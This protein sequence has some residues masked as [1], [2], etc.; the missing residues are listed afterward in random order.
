MSRDVKS[1]DVAALAAVPVKDRQAAVAEGLHIDFSTELPEYSRPELPAYPV[2]D[3]QAAVDE[4]Y[5]AL[6]A[7]PVLP[8]R[9]RQLNLLSKSK[10][11]FLIKPVAWRLVQFPGQ[12]PRL[13]VV[14]ERP[15]QPLPLVSQEKPVRY[16]EDF[17]LKV[18][19]PAVVK[20]LREL[21]NLGTTHGNIRPEN[22]FFR[23]QTNSALVL[24]ESFM[25]PAGA[26]QAPAFESLERALANPTARGDG[27]LSSDLFSLGMTVFMLMTGIDLQ[28]EAGQEALQAERLDQGTFM[29]LITSYRLPHRI[30]ELLRGLLTDTPEQRWTLDELE[31]WLAG[32]K[33]PHRHIPPQRRPSRGFPF[34]GMDCA[35]VLALGVA[36]GK[37][38][39]KAAEIFVSN[40][41]E[42]WMVRS[43][44]AP[45]LHEKIKD[46][47]AQA[48]R[49][50][51]TLQALALGSYGLMALS[52]MLPLYLKRQA[53]TLGGIGSWLASHYAD[54]DVRST[55][56]E[57]IKIR[58]PLMWL[59]VYQKMGGDWARLAR[60][61]EK[62]AVYIRKPTPGYGIE[63]AL[64]E[65]N[66]ALPCQ[67]VLCEGYLVSRV[68]DVLPVLEAMAA[69]GAGRRHSLVDR[70]LLAFLATYADEVTDELLLGVAEATNAPGQSMIGLLRV[71]VTIER[72]RGG[73]PC[74]NLCRWVNEALQPAVNL[75][76]NTKRREIIR[77]DIESASKSAS[78]SKMLDVIDNPQQRKLDHEEFA[79]AIAHYQTYEQ[80]LQVCHKQYRELA[81]R[82]LE[83]TWR[84][85]P[86]V[87]GV[88]ACLLVGLGIALK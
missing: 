20:A 13:V 10:N 43:N 86:A 26:L 16:P 67:S 52:P 12:K 56:A 88:F 32:G 2:C 8:A 34:L 83:L 4:R 84:Y 51:G 77:E 9:Y 27:N 57:Y 54:S 7:H 1:V 69:A 73:K 22:I 64:Y 18:L 63:R 44:S 6:L 75:Y 14:A 66:P 42:V 28:G 37:Q 25:V 19:L 15:G 46:A 81:A 80:Q 50:D 3:S 74:P 65:L 29:A 47:L 24:G 38:W 85:A 11:A 40:E 41:F 82:T 61:Y 70:H 21:E 30:M 31:N 35:T 59:D 48:R 33:I 36:V 62:L 71:L 45:E 87:S 72:K 17:I 76:R 23:D 79:Q 60:S 78:L 39:A 68:E 53:V 55:A 5:I 58:L 49:N